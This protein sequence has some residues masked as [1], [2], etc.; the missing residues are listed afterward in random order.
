MQIILIGNASIVMIQFLN[1][2]NAVFQQ[3]VRNATQVIIY[4]QV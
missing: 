1:V 3:R 4:T 2:F